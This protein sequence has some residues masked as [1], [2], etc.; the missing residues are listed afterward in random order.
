MWSV[1]HK[2]GVLIPTWKQRLEVDLGIT[3][4]LQPKSKMGSIQSTKSRNTKGYPYPLTPDAVTQIDGS[5]FVRTWLLGTDDEYVAN[6]LKTACAIPYKCLVNGGRPN[7]FSSWVLSYGDTKTMCEYR[8]RRTKKEFGSLICD[9]AISRFIVHGMAFYGLCFVVKGR[10]KFCVI[11]ERAS[12]Y[13]R[14]RQIGLFE[15]MSVAVNKAFELITKELYVEEL[16]DKK[17][18][19]QTNEYFPYK[20]DKHVDMILRQTTMLDTIRALSRQH[21]IRKFSEEQNKKLADYILAFYPLE[22]NCRPREYV[23]EPIIHRDTKR[24]KMTTV[25]VN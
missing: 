24:V 16:K 11:T 2:V 12:D 1:D 10:P 17:F 4:Q 13:P 8:H 7:G 6:T 19:H 25:E 9:G 14:F 18:F 15:Q 3:N 21:E 23:E 20:Y 5:T 22:N